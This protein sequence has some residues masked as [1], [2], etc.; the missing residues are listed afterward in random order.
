MSRAQSLRHT[1]STNALQHT[2]TEHQRRLDEEERELT[3][4]Q[5][6]VQVEREE[7][8]LRSLK[9]KDAREEDDEQRRRENLNGR[10]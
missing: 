4:R 9:R 7:L 3:I 5:R 10:E 1:A 2:R 8:E 6:R